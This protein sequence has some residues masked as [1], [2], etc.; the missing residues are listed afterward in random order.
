MRVWDMI[1]RAGSLLNSFN[2]THNMMYVCM[3]TFVRLYLHKYDYELNIFKKWIKPHKNCKR[4]IY[5]PQMPPYR[6]THVCTY[7]CTYVCWFHLPLCLIVYTQMD[8]LRRE[9]EKLRKDNAAL[10]AQLS[11]KTAR[12]NQRMDNYF[13]GQVREKWGTCVVVW[14]WQTRVYTLSCTHMCM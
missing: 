13:R 7:I 1:Y 2:R 10:M 14:R 12:E 4:C 3:Y 6:G 8:T 9:R 11:L 5:C